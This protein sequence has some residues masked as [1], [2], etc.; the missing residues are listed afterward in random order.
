MLSKVVA[1]RSYMAGESQGGGRQ[2]LPVAV[3]RVANQVY[4]RCM[5]YELFEK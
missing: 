3:R 1:M 2:K 5:R 4:G